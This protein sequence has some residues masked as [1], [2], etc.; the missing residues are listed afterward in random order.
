MVSSDGVRDESDPVRS[1]E[2][3]KKKLYK[4]ETDF[5]KKLDEKEREWREQLGEKDRRLQS[6]ERE[7][8]EAQ[9]QVASLREALK[10]A[11]GQ[12]RV[13]FGATAN[14]GVCGFRIQ[15]AAGGTSGR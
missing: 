11:E 9:K 10:S 4:I 2:E 8:E 5:V 12:C 1:E 7:K 6:L 13:M 15:A 3:Y 14:L